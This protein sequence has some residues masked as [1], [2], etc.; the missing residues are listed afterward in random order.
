M[1]LNN[2][3]NK[4]I[5]TRSNFKKAYHW[6]DNVCQ[7]TFKEGYAEAIPV[8]FAPTTDNSTKMNILGFVGRLAYIIRHPWNDIKFHYYMYHWHFID[9]KKENKELL[10]KIDESGLPQEAKNN[11]RKYLERD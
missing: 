6:I 7:T 8:I 3:V 10:N 2:L 5:G 4:Y 1:N 9:R 11:I